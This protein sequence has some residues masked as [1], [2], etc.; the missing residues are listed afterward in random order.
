MCN[1]TTM[2][3]LPYQ[4]LT[5]DTVPVGGIEDHL[6]RCMRKFIIS[7]RSK[8]FLIKSFMSASSFRQ[9]VPQL[10]RSQKHSTQLFIVA[11]RQ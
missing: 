11:S 5:Y 9:Y 1:A 3:V 8:I 4:G 6:K 10:A 7:L 2:S